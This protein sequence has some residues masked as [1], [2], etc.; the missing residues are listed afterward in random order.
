MKRAIIYC[1]T[2]TAQGD[3]NFALDA[4]TYICRAYCERHGYEVTEVITD[5]G[6]SGTKLDRPG[7][8]RVRELIAEGQAEAV[9]VTSPDRLTRQADHW[10]LLHDELSRAGIAVLIANGANEDDSID[11]VTRAIYEQYADGVS[12]G[13]ITR[14]LNRRAKA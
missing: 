13:E 10:R 11:Q 5:A 1:R 9:V 7:L 14:R 8:A 4:Q 2:A 3:S 12:I 6:Q